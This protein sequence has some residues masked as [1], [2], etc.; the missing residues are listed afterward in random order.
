MAKENN[1]KKLIFFKLD[2]PYELFVRIQNQSDRH[3]KTIRQILLRGEVVLV[4]W[5]GRYQS[6]KMT[7]SSF[8]CTSVS[9]CYD[10]A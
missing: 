6:E 1:K 5:E 7:R 3:D 2:I 10:L 9:F 8:A 4:F